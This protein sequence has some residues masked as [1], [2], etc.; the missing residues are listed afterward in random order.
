MIARLPGVIEA[1]NVDDTPSY[2][3]DW[4]P[5]LCAA[6]GLEAPDGLD[7]ENLWPVLT[8]EA[9]LEQRKP[10]IWVFPEYR[11][12]VAVRIGDY[13]VVRQR[14]RTKNPGDW[15]VYNLADDR[16]ESNDLAKEKTDLIRQAKQ[17]LKQ[18]VAPNSVFPLT[19]PGVN[20]ASS[21][22]DAA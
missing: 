12:Q 19:I 7:G 18:Q 1:G 2:F 14:L 3:A 17:I 8:G 4:F 10:M 15:E 9:N 6:T 13:K 22:A 21:D 16:S 20:D 11:G 5:T